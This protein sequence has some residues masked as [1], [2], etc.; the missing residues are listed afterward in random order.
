MRIEVVDPDQVIVLTK[1]L[2]AITLKL[3]AAGI[4]IVQH[5]TEICKRLDR[6]ILHMFIQIQLHMFIQIHVYSNTI[7]HVYSNTTY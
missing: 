3:Q 2:Y 6:A 7:A 4:P 5:V 1:W